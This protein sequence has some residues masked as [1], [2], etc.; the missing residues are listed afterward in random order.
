MR[1]SWNGMELVS[2][3]EWNWSV[4]WYLAGKQ[5]WLGLM[6]CDVSRGVVLD[7]EDAKCVIGEMLSVCRN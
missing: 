2:G 6:Y 7:I 1:K 5:R 4:V 3:M